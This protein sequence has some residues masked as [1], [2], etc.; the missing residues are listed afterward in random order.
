VLR[1]AL[2]NARRHSNSRRV[3]VDLCRSR[4]RMRLSVADDGRGFDWASVREGV[5]FSA[6]RERIRSVSGRLE[7]DSK[8]GTGTRVNVEVPL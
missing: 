4:N 8:P 7:I 5:G 2:V 1:E 6:M 3:E